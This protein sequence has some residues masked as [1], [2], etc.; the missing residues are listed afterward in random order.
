[1]AKF[2]GVIGYGEVEETS[3]GVWEEVITERA[4]K[5]DILR[6]TRRWENGQQLNDDLAINNSFSVVADAYAYQNFF[7]MRYLVWMGT[8]WKITNVEVQRPRLLL[9]VGGRYNGPNGA[10]KPSRGHARVY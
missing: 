7:A 1:M 10:S 8:S 4:Y 2:Y 6:N 3:A 5:G 9:T